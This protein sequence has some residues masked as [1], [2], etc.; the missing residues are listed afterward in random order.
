VIKL[1]YP[2]VKLDDRKEESAMSVTVTDACRNLEDQLNGWK[3]KIQ[4]L[5]RQVETLRDTDRE[6]IFPS[7]RN[8]NAC[9][10][11]M[12]AR[13]EQLRHECPEFWAARLEETEQGT[14]D[15]RG[16]YEETMD[17]IGRHAPVS[18]PG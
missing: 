17:Y 10:V 4:D 9:V 13:I 11:E 12:N 8:L 3:T 2:V 7:I 1:D 14:I 18:I 5:L 15:M 6:R 16:R